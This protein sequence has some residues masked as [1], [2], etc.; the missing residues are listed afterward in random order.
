MKIA[1]LRQHPKWILLGTIII[2]AAVGGAL[3]IFSNQEP[4]LA[5][6]S[7]ENPE[8]KTADSV[9]R[10]EPSINPLSAKLQ[11]VAD[12]SALLIPPTSAEEHLADLPATGR[13]D[14]FM[15]VIQAVGQPRSSQ[16]ASTSNPTGA[17]SAQAG[18][19]GGTVPSVPTTS[20][21]STVDLPPIPPVVLAPPPAPLPSIPV[22][23]A[24]VSIP[25]SP[26]YAPLDAMQAVELSGVVQLGDRV[27][28]IV[29]ESDSKTSR[30][31]FAG[32][33]L[34]GGQIRI[35]S[36]DLSSQEPLVIFEYQGKEYYRVVGS[37]GQTEVS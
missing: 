21:S 36:I 17:A 31:L 10:V 13:S 11:S 35:K 6:N 29:R 16:S 9:K 1:N 20:V 2:A 5:G 25:S 14:P 33:S 26:S 32:D 15:S 3:R 4:N 12:P 8:H 37:G 23:N 27:A 30:H 19:T 28:V 24:P 22:A 7:P 34:A 18:V